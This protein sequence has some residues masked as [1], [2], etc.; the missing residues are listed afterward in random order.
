MK[1]SPALVSPAVDGLVMGGASLLLFLGCA[2]VERAGGA[3]AFARAW[4]AVAVVV[5][6]LNGAHFAATS[7]RLYRSREA[8]ARFPLT[9]ALVPAVVLG[10]VAASF[11]WPLAVA[12]YFIKLFLLWSP[13][14]Y[15]G[16]TVG[17]AV[18]YARRA[19][20][21][22]EPLERRC[23]SAFVFGTFLF[24]VA[25]AEVQLNRFDY[26]GVAYPSLGLPHWVASA[27]LAATALAGA[28]L[29]GLALRRRA[30]LPW[31]F[32]VPPAAQLVW[33]GFG[34]GSALFYPLVPMFHGAQ[35]L[36][37]SW[38]LH[39]SERR[40]E[41]SRDSDAVE[42]ARWAAGSLAGYVVLFLALPKLLSAATGT[43]FVFATA[44]FTGGVQLHHFFVDG[45]IWRL[46]APA[47]AKTM[48][49]ALALAF[50]L[51]L[52]AVAAPDRFVVVRT[53]AG[54]F[55]F[56]LHAG[57]PKH[58]AKLAKLFASGAYDGVTVNKLDPTRFAAFGSAPNA[59]DAIR[60][61]VENGGP[62]VPGA[63]VMAHQHG[64][65]D[66]GETA[67]VVLY[68]ELKAMEGRFSVVGELAGGRN[69]FE[70]LKSAP[71]DGASRPVTAV[72]ILSTEVVAAIPEL[73]GPGPE[74]LGGAGE[75]SRR[76]ALLR[77]AAL[78]AFVA[79]ALFAFAPELGRWAPSAALL[80]VLAAFFLVF[81]ACVPRATSSAWISVPL[82][83]ATIGV[84]K[85]MSRFES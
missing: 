50:A 70:A 71:L 67:F 52:P 54:D 74:A 13:Y 58:G 48:G 63:V 44:V 56:K 1:D 10:G 6:A 81:A 46:R 16:Q 30:R 32:F 19:G 64:D 41:K 35:Y 33:F 66:A 31:L 59:P 29:L 18:L 57:A 77:A 26:L 24:S 23:L 28:G 47:L 65:A 80:G 12:P 79:A 8:I 55:A 72:K 78:F 42:S 9:A 62:A 76:N 11:A 60:L 14:H 43:T 69:T 51:A 82:L 25:R 85:L 40:Q 39:L 75:K 38:Y 61:P 84:F 17:L 20:T 73:R 15:S 37:V 49:A 5:A 45:V 2:A 36:L 4:D 3:S 7:W 22:L 27:A 83:A 34:P 53:D 68:A 21:P